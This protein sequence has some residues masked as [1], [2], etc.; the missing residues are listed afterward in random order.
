MSRKY[1]RIR[2]HIQAF[3]YPNAA[4]GNYRLNRVLD[5]ILTCAT[6]LG[7]VTAILFLVTL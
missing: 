7:I 4:T 6:T 1:F 5:G 2:K 3:R